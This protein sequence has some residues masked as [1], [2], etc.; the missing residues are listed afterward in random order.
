MGANS[1]RVARLKPQTIDELKSHV[2]VDFTTDEIKE[3]YDDYQSRLQ[4]G[5]KEL[6]RKQ[7]VQVYNS[8]FQG[9]ASN[10]AEHVFRT[11]DANGN[12]MV[13]FKEFIL[14][15]CISG[16]TDFETKLK[17]A[18]NMY[19]INGDG[20]ITKDEMEQIIE[21]FY[22]MTNCKTPSPQELAEDLFKFMDCNQD[23]KIL[24]EEFITGVSQDD[25][26]IQML[27][28]SSDTNEG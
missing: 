2:N 24:W 14:G 12:G 5:Q 18:F 17:W 3:W 4:P 28:A 20:F 8:V 25:T 13:D 23:G 11:F 7:F 9:D 19:D 6:S 16:S 1:G 10:F 22:K 21:A 27:Q 15:L 26:M